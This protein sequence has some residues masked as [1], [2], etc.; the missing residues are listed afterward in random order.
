LKKGDRVTRGSFI[1]FSGRNDDN[2]R[3]EVDVVILK[4]QKKV[5]QFSFKQTIDYFLC[6]SLIC[7]SLQ[8]QTL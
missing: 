3:Q 7:E 6:Q 1:G 4:R 2:D 8:A 5:V